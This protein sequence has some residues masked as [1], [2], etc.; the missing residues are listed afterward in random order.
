MRRI[1]LM[2]VALLLTGCSQAVDVRQDYDA[3]A[4]FD[5][6]KTYAWVHPY[7]G[8]GQAKD[9]EDMLRIALTNE[10]NAKGLTYAAGKPDIWVDYALGMQTMPGTIDWD[11][12]TLETAKNSAVYTS[13]GGVLVIDFID[14]KRDRMVWRGV[15]TG[16]VN[17]DPSEEIMR[18][19]VNNAVKKVMKQYPPGM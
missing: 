2:A 15:G 3:D 18:R 7:V 5:Q 17:V 8:T 4:H 11:K 19:N 14:A 10:L 16:A 13:G 6:Y 1:L 9:W 12:Q